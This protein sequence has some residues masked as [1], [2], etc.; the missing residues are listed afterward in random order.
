MAMEGNGL[1]DLCPVQTSEGTFFLSFFWLQGMWDLRSPS[2]D[3]ISTPCMEAQ[4]P[5]HWATREVPEGT[6]W[7]LGRP[8]GVRE[9]AWEARWFQLSL[10]TGTGSLHKA[11]VSG[12]HSAYLVEEIQLFPD[13]E[14]VRNL[15]LAP[16]QVGKGLILIWGLQGGRPW[17]LGPY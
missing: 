1:T 4:R 3:Q 7:Q 13:P 9:R 17:V 6:F 12:D 15:Q 11:V 10:S 8:S 2:R 16:T 5:N 14:P